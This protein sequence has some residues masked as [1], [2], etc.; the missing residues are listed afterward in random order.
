ML[1]FHQFQGILDFFFLGIIL[2]VV[3]SRA[4]T[5]TLSSPLIQVPAATVGTIAFLVVCIVL[6]AVLLLVVVYA[7]FMLL[8]IACIAA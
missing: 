8:I 6:V 4:P 7:T 5:A 1:P 2:I 3:F